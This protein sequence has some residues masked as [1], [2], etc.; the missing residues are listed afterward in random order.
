MKS[1]SKKPPLKDLLLDKYRADPQ[2]FR[3]YLPEV[4]QALDAMLPPSRRIRSPF[5]LTEHERT[6]RQKSLSQLLKRLDDG[7]ITPEEAV[8]GLE[9]CATLIEDDSLPREATHETLVRMVRVTTGK[10]PGSVKKSTTVPVGEVREEEKETL[11]HIP[12]VRGV[13]LDLTEDMRLISVSIYPHKIRERR[14]ALRLIGIARDFKPD[15]AQHH[16]G[17]L[18]EISP[19]A[20]T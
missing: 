1:H 8:R 20:T 15:V 19:H 10:S 13:L 2:G 3:R 4:A 17:Y 14:K 5:G 16:D 6:H 18:A 12:L 9:H 11:K 7:T